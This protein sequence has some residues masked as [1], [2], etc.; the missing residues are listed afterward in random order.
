MYLMNLANANFEKNHFSAERHFNVSCRLHLHYAMEIVCVR[1]GTVRMNV[2]GSV[3]DIHANECTLIL[4]LEAHSFETPQSSECFVLVF[5]P[6]LVEDVYRRVCDKQLDHVVCSPAPAVFD[7]CD[8]YL[9]KI[10]QGYDE[11]SLKAVLYPLLTEILS[12]CSFVPA[13]RQ[14]EGTIFLEAVRYINRN[15]RTHDVSLSATAL[16]LGVHPVYLSRAFR[17]S[18]GI[19]YTRFIN[20]TRASYAARLLREK[21]Q[22]NIS[23]IAYEAGFGSIRNFNRE[24]KTLYGCSP[25]EF[26]SRMHREE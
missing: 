13:K 7:L 9:P 4:P 24:F 22:S 20:S 3:R 23:E 8:E 15:F 2:N 5:S 18:C 16:A 14:Y 11:L 17:E 12:K 19:Q 6:E 26:L 1:V 21:P 25:A 10:T